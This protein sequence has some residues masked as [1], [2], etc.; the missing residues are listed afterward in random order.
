MFSYEN[1]YPA[2]LSG[3]GRKQPLQRSASVFLK[4]TNNL[5]TNIENEER[6]FWQILITNLKGGL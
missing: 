6:Q 5:K 3:T 2:Y 1:M 4:N